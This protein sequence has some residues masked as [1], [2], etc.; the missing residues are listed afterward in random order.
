MGFYL[1][2]YERSKGM[3]KSDEYNL[4]KDSKPVSKKELIE[5][6]EQEMESILPNFYTVF[7]GVKIHS[8]KIK[9]FSER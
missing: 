8:K 5:A 6:R 7:M 1:G 3:K 4:T 2:F 9:S